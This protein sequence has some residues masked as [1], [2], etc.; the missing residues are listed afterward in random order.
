MSLGM[1]GDATL[2]VNILLMRFSFTR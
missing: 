2:R 1:V